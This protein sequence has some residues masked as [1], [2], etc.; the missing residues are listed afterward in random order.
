MKNCF[1]ILDILK[2]FLPHKAN[3]HFIGREKAVEII[4]L[5]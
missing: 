4:I 1:L 2:Y 5:L 3:Q